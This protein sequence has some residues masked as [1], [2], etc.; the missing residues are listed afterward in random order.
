MIAAAQQAQALLGDDN[1]LSGLILSV[2]AVVHL[3]ASVPIEKAMQPFVA[4]WHCPICHHRCS[5]RR[6]CCCFGLS[7]QLDS[8]NDKLLASVLQSRSVD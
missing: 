4:L 8:Q 3:C 6:Q 2:D 1:N 5:S 7:Q